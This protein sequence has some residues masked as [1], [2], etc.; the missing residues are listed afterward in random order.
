MNIEQNA[1][2]TTPATTTQSVPAPAAKPRTR[3]V[4]WL[5]PTVDVWEKDDGLLLFLDVPGVAPDAFEIRAEGST[6]T[7]QGVRASGD[8][9]WHRV[10]TLPP[11]IDATQIAAKAENGV[12]TLT[13]P[14]A[15]AA[16]PRR[17]E[18]R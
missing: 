12:L 4:T 7:V 16:K 14:R 13:L 2:T 10:F 5:R 9:G 3:A 8:R 18:V 17:I 1:A 15:E 11:T 6:L